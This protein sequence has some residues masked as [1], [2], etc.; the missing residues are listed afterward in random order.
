MVKKNFLGTFEAHIKNQTFFP[1]L[2]ELKDCLNIWEHFDANG[3]QA[4]IEM[5]IFCINHNS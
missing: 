5:K 4:I 1:D 2:I 3:I